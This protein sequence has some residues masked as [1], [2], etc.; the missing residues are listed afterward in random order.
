MKF[1]DLNC[2]L[3]ESFGAYKMGDDEQILKHITS[4][5][6]A[7]GYHAGD[8]NVMAK[9]VKVAGDNKV[10]VG[11]HPGYPDLLGFGR[12]FIQTDPDDVY[13]FMIYQIGALQ[14]FCHI[15]NIQMQHVKPH[16]ALFNA[17]AVNKEIAEAIAKAVYDCNPHL[18]LFGLSGSEL[19]RA[20]LKA[21]L[22]VANEVF[23]DR[24]YQADGTLTPRSHKHALIHEPEIAVK[25]VI[26]MVK[27]G[28]VQAVDGTN[29][30][31][32]ADTI[33]V[34]GDGKEALDFVQ[35]LR[36]ALQEEGIIIRSVLD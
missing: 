10:K 2:D 30:P 1:V 31:I 29:V 17:A 34:H 9:T 6:I 23:A 14:G 21:G 11:A 35:E 22:K 26:K 8:H 12:R 32:Q 15:H 33:C 3:G 19:I 28:C 20:G 7:C 16:G 25:Q 18:V 36:R 13:H 5:N 27:T 24:T 4:A